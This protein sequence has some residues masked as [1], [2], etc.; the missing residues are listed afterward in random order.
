MRCKFIGG[1][2]HGQVSE[3]PGNPPYQIIGY[4]QPEFKS[5]WSEE[6]SSPIANQIVD[7]KKEIY[8]MRKIAGPNR[9][10]SYYA[11]TNWTDDDVLELFF[12]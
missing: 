9:V 12:T 8:T 11:P 6:M 4:I 5:I 3:F 1:S 7:V 10:Y 2:R